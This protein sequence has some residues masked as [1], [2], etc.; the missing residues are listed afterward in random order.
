VAGARLAAEADEEVTGPVR[1]EEGQR[2]VE[3]AGLDPPLLL[4]SQELAGE[5]V[6]GVGHEGAG[7]PGLE[8]ALARP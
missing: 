2:A 3:G 4:A 5:V 6:D 7:D 8:V 1:A